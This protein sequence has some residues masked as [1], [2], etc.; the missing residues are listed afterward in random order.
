MSR[1]FGR[2]ELEANCHWSKRDLMD[3]LMPIVRRKRRP[4]I[5]ADYRTSGPGEPLPVS[6]PAAAIE[7]LREIEPDESATKTTQETGS[8]PKPR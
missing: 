5:E 7:P 1:D 2:N 6:Q 8:R 4:L 3:G